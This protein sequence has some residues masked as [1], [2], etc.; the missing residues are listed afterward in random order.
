LISQRTVTDRFFPRR[1][2]GGARKGE[3][4]AASARA[5][6]VLRLFC[7]VLSREMT[8]H[9]AAPK[10]SCSDASR[11]AA[12]AT[13]SITRNMDFLDRVAFTPFS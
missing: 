8:S 6:E 3:P 7:S 10:R 5:A 13:G 9:A 11:Q 4:M 12:A 1:R 2:Y